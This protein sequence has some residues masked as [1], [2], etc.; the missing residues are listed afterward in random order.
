MS[1]VEQGKLIKDA[2][3]LGTLVEINTTGERGH[4]SGYSGQGTMISVGLDSG[5]HVGYYAPRGLTIVDESD[6]ARHIANVDNYLAAVEAL[7]DEGVNR[8][9]IVT[10][11]ERLTGLSRQEARD[12]VYSTPAGGIL[13]NC[14]FDPA[15]IG[16]VFPWT[17]DNKED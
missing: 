5:A 10:V 12:I 13:I 8:L 9:T 15:K 7:L 1:N 4:V 16:Y 3:P 14:G 6:K 11:V 2:Y 17:K